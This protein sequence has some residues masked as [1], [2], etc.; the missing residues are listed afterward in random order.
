MENDKMQIVNNVLFGDIRIF[1]EDN[2][3]L[4]CGIDVANALGYSKPRNALALHAKG[5]LKRGALTKGGTQ[6]LTFIPEGDVYRLIIKSKL[7]SAEEFEHWLFDEV[8]PTIR[9]TGGYV[10]DVES[11]VNSYFA[12]ADDELKTQVL[13][14]LT[15]CKNNARKFMDMVRLSGMALAS[16]DAFKYEGSTTIS[17][18]AKTLHDKYLIDVGPGR[19]HKWLR[20]NGYFMKKADFPQQRWIS[21][22][23]FEVR[24]HRVA[25]TDYPT[26]RAYITVKGQKALFSEIEK[27]FERV[28]H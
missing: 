27:A 11:F 14:V 1:V 12:N 7:P 4:F 20:E 21:A 5:A 28:K 22:G 23:L 24:I 15:D 2:T 13:N 10:N 6:E 26:R 3:V 9:T 8:L 19:L 16:L 25:A 18:F 17:E